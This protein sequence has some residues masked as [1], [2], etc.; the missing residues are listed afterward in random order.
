M[1]IY[2]QVNSL[3]LFEF[4]VSIEDGS[5]SLVCICNPFLTG[6]QN[7]INNTDKIKAQQNTWDMRYTRT[8]KLQKKKKET[9][10]LP[11]FIWILTSQLDLE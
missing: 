3:L 8:S 11:S 1:Y 5:I 6:K 2:E 9:K 4:F 10:N 7:Y